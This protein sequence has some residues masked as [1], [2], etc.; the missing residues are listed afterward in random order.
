MTQQSAPPDSAVRTDSVLSDS[1]VRTGS[2]VPADGNASA[3]AR[4][5][6]ADPASWPSPP[7]FDHRQRWSVQL[8]AD[9]HHEAWLLTWLPGQ[10]TELHDHGGAHGAFLVVS[11]QLTEDVIADH[12]EPELASLHWR[13]DSV[14]GFGAHHIHRV[15][16][17]G[18]EPAVSVHVYQPGLTAMSQYAIEPGGGVRLVRTDRQGVDW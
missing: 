12:G 9:T 3:L 1:T 2:A 8:H 15:H 7:V 18:T 10:G 6:A 17:T 11:G 4:A 13:Q 16:N 14:R 5:Y